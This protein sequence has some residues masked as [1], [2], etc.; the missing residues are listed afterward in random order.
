MYYVYF[1]TTYILRVKVHRCA[2]T[3]ELNKHYRVQYGNFD[4]K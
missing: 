1:Y 2:F 4:K 3:N